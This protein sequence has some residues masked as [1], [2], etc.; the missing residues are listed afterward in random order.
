[1][2]FSLKLVS[3]SGEIIDMP[4]TIDVSDYAGQ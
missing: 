1:M 2:S 4:M 3:D